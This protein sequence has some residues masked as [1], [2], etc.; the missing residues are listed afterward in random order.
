ML[1]CT[2]LKDDL[3]E[4]PRVTNFYS[5]LQCGKCTSICPAAHAYY[6]DGDNGKYNPREIVQI[7]KTDPEYRDLDDYAIENCYHCYTCKSVCPVGNSVSDI[8][9]VLKERGKKE[10]GD[11]QYR[12]FYEKGLCVI[13]E[14]LSLDEFDDWIGYR[15]I[16]HNTKK[17]REEFGLGGLHR[18]IPPDSIYEIQKIADLT[19]D[20]RFKKKKEELETPK[21][22]IPKSKIYLF[23]SC[24]ADLHYPGMTESIKWVFDNL[25]VDYIDDPNQSSCTGF[26]YYANAIP[27]STMLVANARNFALAEQAGYSNVAPVCVTSYGVLTESKELLESGL[28]S[29]ANEILKK[30]GLRFKDQVNISHISEIFYKFRDK[31]KPKLKFDF[32]GLKVATHHG[33]HYTKMHKKTAIPYLLDDIVSIT[34]AQPVYYPEKDLCCGLGFDHTIHNRDHSRVVAARKL[35]SIEDSG[36]E[37]V[38]HA[39]PGCQITLDR[40]QPYIEKTTGGES[41]LVHLNYAQFIALAMGADP[42]ETVGIQ[43]HS[44]RLEHILEDFDIL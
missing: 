31:I 41:G 30:I 24:Y 1:K 44:N 26:A 18:E 17:I 11:F 25:G 12:S 27:F 35:K 28:H 42:Y 20:K 32:D 21:K 19:R 13:P 6:V 29:E 33:C 10:Y 23:K 4:D 3:L 38:I 15:D 5:C 22:V 37:V 8:I 43:T 14:M 2:G 9:K 34:G 36:A 7:L 40:N 16:L 39:C